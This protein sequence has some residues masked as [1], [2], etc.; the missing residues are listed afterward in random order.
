V[1]TE[2]QPVNVAS[3]NQDAA[4]S[5]RH[6]YFIGVEGRLSQVL[7]SSGKLYT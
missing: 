1:K 7:L 4:N 2:Q 5:F 3:Q 6:K